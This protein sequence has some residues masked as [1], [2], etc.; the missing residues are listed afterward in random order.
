MMCAAGPC[1]PRVGE[2]VRERLSR[3]RQATVG[4]GEQR[5]TDAQL[6]GHE[7][8]VHQGQLRTHHGN[9]PHRYLLIL[10]SRLVNFVY[11]FCLQQF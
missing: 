1:G 9:K 6:Q 5:W 3:D 4:A 8:P 2:E 10:L 7:T 11:K